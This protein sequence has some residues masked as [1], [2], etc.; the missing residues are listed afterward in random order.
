MKYAN[1]AQAISSSCWAILPEKLDAIVDLVRARAIDVRVDET[2][3]AELQAARP[4][5]RST[6][7][8]AVVP[9]F[10]TISQRMNLLSAFSGGTSTELLGKQFDEAMSDSDVSSIVL[11]I[12]SPGGSTDGVAEVAKKILDAR[13]QKP[14]VAAVNSMSAS[15]A[16]WIASAADEIHVTPSGMVGSIG[17]F[18]LHNDISEMNEK[19]GVRPTYVS[20][21]KYKVEGNPDE[22]LTD[23]A[24]AAL[25]SLV[26]EFYGMFTAAVA[27]GRGVNVSDV[28]DGFGQG[29]VVTA[30]EGVRLGMA[31]RVMTLDESIKRASYLSRSR[32][33]TTKALRSELESENA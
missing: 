9:V 19:L 30:K 26:D 22:P 21:G 6:G 11:E 27:K 28:R 4:Q 2:V 5:K 15:A 32:K 23:E 3:V 16:Y 20:A 13:G 7:T 12:D 17:V 31:D 33:N 14:I 1:I 18:A 8:V 29:R 24:H 10:G 25:Q